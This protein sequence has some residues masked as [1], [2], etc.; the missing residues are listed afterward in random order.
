MV[1]LKWPKGIPLTEYSE[2]FLQGMLDRMAM[3]YNKYGAIN[4]AFPSK[5]NAIETLNLK[6]Q[7]YYKDKN[8]EKLID[9]ANYAMIEFMLPAYPG[10]K[11]TPTDGS[12]GRIF[13]G[14]INPVLDR[15][16]PEKNH[17]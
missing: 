14:E 13:H 3:S 17:E 9:I 6:L 16:I 2:E 15:N 11:Y 4:N 12:T 8:T 5:V 1:E 10:A 7:E